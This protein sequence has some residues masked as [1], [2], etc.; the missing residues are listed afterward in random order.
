MC[1]VPLVIDMVPFFNI[2]YIF[3][4]EKSIFIYDILSST[5]GYFG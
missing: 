4:S 2:M 5:L 3:V 1:R